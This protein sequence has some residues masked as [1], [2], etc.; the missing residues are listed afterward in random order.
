M[1]YTLSAAAVIQRREASKGAREL[2]I[3]T[4]CK[5]PWVTMEVGARF[6]VNQKRNSVHRL[7]AE[8][9]AAY[10]DRSFKAIRIRQGEYQIERIA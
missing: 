8:A 5:Y 6:A 2:G 4:N 1:N 10:L 3:P 9:H 7:I